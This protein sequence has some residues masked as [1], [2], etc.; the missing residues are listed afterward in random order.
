MCICDMLHKCA[1]TG[2]VAFNKHRPIKHAYLVLSITHT[3]YIIAK[4]AMHMQVCTHV[5]DII[6]VEM[7]GTDRD[8]KFNNFLCAG[9]S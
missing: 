8:D 2:A 4:S 1:F 9:D 5:H 6:F 7:K 3:H